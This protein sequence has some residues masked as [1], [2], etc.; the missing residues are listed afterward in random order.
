MP[1]SEN[2]PENTNPKEAESDNKTEL[3]ENIST[4]DY[5]EKVNLRLKKKSRFGLSRPKKTEASKDEPALIQSKEELP[6]NEPD[7]QMQNIEPTNK[8]QPIVYENQKEQTTNSDNETVIESDNKRIQPE[9][10]DEK[11][12]SFFGFR[13]NRNKAQP[14]EKMPPIENSIEM[15]MAESGNQQQKFES[16]TKLLVESEN[17]AFTSET[18]AIEAP[19]KGEDESLPTETPTGPAVEQNSIP[20]EPAENV[21]QAPAKSESQPEQIE[22]PVAPI[23]TSSEPENK[24]E[25][26][27]TEVKVPLTDSVENIEKYTDNLKSLLPTKAVICIGEYPINILLKGSFEGKKGYGVLPIFVE[28]SS[29]DVIKWSQGRLDQSNV[30]GLDEDIGTHFW[31]DILPHF[32]D[33][34]SFFARIKSK[35]LEKLQGVIIVSSTWSGVGSALLPTLNS[36][37]KEWNINSLT[38]AILPSKAQPL[39]GQ[40]NTFA[41]L[42]ILT[43]KD[44][45][46]IVLLDRDNLEDYTGVDRDGYAINGNDITNYLLELMLA[47]ESFVPEL[48]ELSKSFGSKMFSVL[49]APGVSLKI[50]GSLENMLNTTLV[51]PLFSFDLSTA[52]LLYV[53]IRMPFNLKDKLPRGKI[54][55]AVANWFKD[56][57]NL[58]S[59]YI[60]DPVY[61]ED[62]TDRIDIAM[63]VG[64]FD[65]AKRFAALEKRV[66]RM[67]NKAVKKGSITEEDWQLITKSL[68]E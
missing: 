17:K 45:T 11:K 28:K 32:V 33:N 62:S 5:F 9:K 37:F 14:T 42:G 7:K 50:Y 58:E 56:K 19:V 8:T 52:S 27:E 10:I 20:S 44:A 34:E 29:D 60:A 46:T 13:R 67:K 30:V 25:L 2:T 24:E 21:Q 65:T 48:N 36:Q 38:L 53:L 63:F 43:S 4:D 6:Q 68:L 61:V 55:L 66:E 49:L 41:S 15:P 59:I 54:E 31:Y 23:V 40:F 39:D 64:G 47:K 22:S 12:R 18:E 1:E 26:A 16:N 3:P 35:P 57:A 51:R